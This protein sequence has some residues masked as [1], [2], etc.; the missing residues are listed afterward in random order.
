MSDHNPR[1]AST[2]AGGRRRG[3]ALPI[4]AVVLTTGLVGV[5]ATASFGQGYGPGFGSG[6]GFGRGVGPGNGPGFGP[7]GYGPGYGPGFR[8]G[9]GP[10]SWRGGPWS[11]G[12]LDPA[13]V[14]ARADRMARYLAIELGAKADQQEKL[15]GIAKVLVKEVLPLREQMFAV[16]T[17]GRDLLTGQTVDR[18]A[19]EKL[20]ADQIATFDA[21]SKRLVSALADAA[22]VL[23]P[24]QRTKLNNL[25][26]SGEGSS[27][28]RGGRG[29]GMGWGMMGG[30]R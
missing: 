11:G 28:G 2:E 4:L 25:L 30:W 10:G 7:G 15:A 19:L 24:E 29:M 1:L 3:K 8:Q 14:E 26:P 23:T 18:A 13:T 6:P 21:A 5:V 22:E 9:G 27:F 17:K 12:K 20:R 16:R